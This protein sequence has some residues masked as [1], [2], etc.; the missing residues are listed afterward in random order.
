MCG[1]YMVCAIVW[2]V[3]TTAEIPC[4]ATGARH[5]ENAP[6]PDR[7]SR[8]SLKRARTTRFCVAITIGN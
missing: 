6:A 4:L 2:R 8:A 1:G 5:F 7:A 3:L